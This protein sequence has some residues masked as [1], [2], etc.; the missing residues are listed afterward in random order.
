MAETTTI[1]KPEFADQLQPY[2]SAALAGSQDLYDTQVSAGYQGFGQPQVVGIG[3]DLSGAIQAQIGG[4]NP[5]TDLGGVQG[6]L[7]GLTNQLQ[8]Q[9]AEMTKAG[10]AGFDQTI[11]D[12]YMNPYQQGVTDDSQR[13]LRGQNTSLPIPNRR[14]EPYGPQH[15]P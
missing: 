5:N 11:M 10:T 6:G 4:F 15:H 7:A 9:A 2:V 14:D 12:S 1:T 3:D 8:Q 13:N